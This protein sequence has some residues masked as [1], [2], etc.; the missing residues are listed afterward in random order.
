MDILESKIKEALLRKAE[1]EAERMNLVEEVARLRK[2]I[3]EI[4]REKQEIK[5]RID[6]IIEKLELYLLRSEA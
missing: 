1:L 3:M 4:E 2:S 6:Q 5:M